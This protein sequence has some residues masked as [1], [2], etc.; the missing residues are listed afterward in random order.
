M[1]NEIE[2]ANPN[3]RV[4]LSTLLQSGLVIT[5]IM[6]FLY[7]VMLFDY[8]STTSVVKKEGLSVIFAIGFVGLIFAW[9]LFSSSSKDE[10]RK[11]SILPKRLKLTLNV[12]L[13]AIAMVSLVALIL[14]NNPIKLGLQSLLFKASPLFVSILIGSV[15]GIGIVAIQQKEETVHWRLGKVLKKENLIALLVE[16]MAILL[17]ISPIISDN[18]IPINTDYIFSFSPWKN[19]YGPS[20]GVVNPVLSDSVD[21]VLPSREYFLKSLE[22]E[23]FPFWNNKITLGTPFGLL[24]FADTF[25]INNLSSLLFGSAYGAVVYHCLKQLI[26]GYFFYL[27]LKSLGLRFSARIF[28]MLTVSFSTFIVAFAAWNVPDS[29]IFIPIIL[30]AFEEYR[31]SINYKWLVVI[32]FAVLF[33]LLSGFPAIILYSLLFTVAYITFR[34]ITDKNLPS[35]KQRIAVLSHLAFA[36]FVGILLSGFSF[37]PTL[38]FFNHIGLGYREGAGLRKFEPETILRF[39]G[40]MGCGSPVSNNFVCPSNFNETAIYTGFL[41]ILLAPFALLNVKYR[42]LG[43]F[44]ITSTILIVSI[45][46]GLFGINTLL[47]RLPILK[48]SSNTRIVALLPIVLAMIGALGFDSLL[49]SKLAPNK[50]LWLII[51]MSFYIL[52]FT[53]GNNLDNFLSLDLLSRFKTCSLFVGSVLLIILFAILKSKSNKQWIAFGMCVILFLDLT[54]GMVAYNG[55]SRADLFYPPT[56]ALTYL[57]ENLESYERF[58]AVDSRNMIPSM[59]LSYSLNSINNHWWVS[60]SYRKVVSTIDEN[61]Y[62]KSKTTQPVFSPTSTDYFS[63][64][65]D[66]MR[67]KYLTI[68]PS[69]IRKIENNSLIFQP[70]YNDYLSLTQTDS[71]IQTFVAPH[72][73]QIDHLSLAVSGVNTSQSFILDLKIELANHP[74]YEGD[75]KCTPMDNVQWIECSINVI[76]VKKGDNV[77]IRIGAVDPSSG[78]KLA[79]VNFDIYQDGTLIYNGSEVK[80]D[81]AFMVFEKDYEGL[82]QFR[83]VYDKGLV[84]Y[85]NVEYSQ[86]LPMVS[87]IIAMNPEQCEDQLTD[88]DLFKTAI[89]ENP[90]RLESGGLA[91]VSNDDTAIISEYLNNSL[92]IKTNATSEKMVILSDTWYPGW[93]ATVDGQPAQ[94]YKTNCIMRG[95]IVP[96]GEHVVRMFYDPTSFKIGLAIT[97]LGL[98]L[99]FSGYALSVKKKKEKG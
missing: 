77:S 97:L 27:F 51:P 81:L 63:Q 2:P 3:K 34:I 78:I 13:V 71:I 17:F 41:S 15:L 80:Q 53:V 83:P 28:G 35:L 52:I 99:V 1:V 47:G 93:R 69:S 40:T 19:E 66:I 43:I 20:S 6:C 86:K 70:E 30:Y 49:R 9:I 75:T 46:F 45:S 39:W 61:L 68:D 10:L 16:I 98:I 7:Y 32:A 90:P 29:L 62:A 89:V 73:Q 26:T 31:R 74:G 24:M 88:I 11:T 44:L 55:A 56:P 38:E 4:K 65:L 64:L 79:S 87:N 82:S 91:T 8:K 18:R 76:T 12:L 36:F 67:V 5:T 95:V 22:D 48:L 37:L 42:K 96:P 54:N 23:G 84:V 72:D 58:V 50:I 59:P 21:N 92:E 94:I 25:T 60:D 85:E 14:P 57:K 33:A